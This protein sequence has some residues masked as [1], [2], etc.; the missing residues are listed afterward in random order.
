MT[1]ANLQ[2]GFIVKVIKEW[3]ILID[4]DGVLGV[5]G[6]FHDI[7]F[8]TT[9]DVRTLSLEINCYYASLRVQAELI[10]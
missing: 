3:T 6:L 4:R 9:D 5:K 8:V 1:D 7:P 2:S 10:K